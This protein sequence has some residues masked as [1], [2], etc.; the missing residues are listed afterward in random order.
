MVIFLK[1]MRQNNKKKLTAARGC[2]TGLKKYG[3][4]M[5]K[6]Q[7]YLTGQEMTG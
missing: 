4:M 6:P 1:S 5:K 2:M 7:A 3:V